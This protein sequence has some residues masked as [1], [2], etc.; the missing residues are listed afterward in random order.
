MTYTTQD[1]SAFR[2]YLLPGEHLPWRGRP[3]PRS[4]FTSADVFLVPFSIMWAGFAVFWES[5]A[6]VGG[7]PVFFLLWGIPFLLMGAYITVG[8]FIYKRI[9]KQHTY[10]A[11]TNERVLTLTTL[12]KP[13][14]QSAF[15][16][17]LPGIS[18]AGTDRRGT[19]QFGQQPPNA[20]WL[21]NTGW[22]FPEF[23]TGGSLAFYDVAEPDRVY[24]LVSRQA[25]DRGD[26][27]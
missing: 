15:I 12:R 24:N 8:R 26:G 3:D 2:R 1:E 5:A 7:A 27:G 9:V 4:L 16:Q 23:S 13:R 18:I 6:I 22:T 20:S 19:V 10:Y 17:T 11:V 14:V 21:A 25:V